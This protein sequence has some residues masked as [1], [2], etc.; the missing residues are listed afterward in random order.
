VFV[1]VR[2]LVDDDHPTVYQ[3]AADKRQAIRDILEMS[4]PKAFLARSGWRPGTVR[5]DPES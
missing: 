3:H 2:A 5:A 4:D 1:Q